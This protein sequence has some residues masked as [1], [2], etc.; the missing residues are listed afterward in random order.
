MIP[1]E[2]IK[3]TMKKR[4]KINFSNYLKDLEPISHN[5]F[6]DDCPNTT[7]GLASHQSY[8]TAEDLKSPRHCII[9]YS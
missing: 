1:L 6:G 3:R 2:I 7:K 9:N 5:F 8:L 4:V